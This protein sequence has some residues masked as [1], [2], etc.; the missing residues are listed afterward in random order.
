MRFLHPAVNHPQR[1]KILSTNAWDAGAANKSSA[2]GANLEYVARRSFQNAKAS[3][4]RDCSVRSS[5]R[6]CDISPWID[7]DP[8]GDSALV[9]WLSSLMDIALERKRNLL[10]SG[11]MKDWTVTATGETEAVASRVWP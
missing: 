10:S 7:P 8:G 9:P 1:E 6:Y 3:A 11:E 4:A 5:P 2:I